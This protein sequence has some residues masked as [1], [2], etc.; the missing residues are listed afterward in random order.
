MIILNAEHTYNRII[1]FDFS[2]CK[3]YRLLAYFVKTKLSFRQC[4]KRNSSGNKVLIYIIY[5]K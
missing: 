2:L 4:L 1:I 3:Y 5:F